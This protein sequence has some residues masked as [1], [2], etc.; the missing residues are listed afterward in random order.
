MMVGEKKARRDEPTGT[1]ALLWL[2]AAI[3]SLI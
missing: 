2:A 3:T 1:E